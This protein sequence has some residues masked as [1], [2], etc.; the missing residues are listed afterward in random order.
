MGVAVWC[1]GLQGRCLIEV[2]ALWPVTL[3]LEYPG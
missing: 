1:F 2:L 3:A